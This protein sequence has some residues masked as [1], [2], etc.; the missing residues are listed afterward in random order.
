MNIRV[1]KLVSSITK[2]FLF[3]AVMVVPSIQAEP[4]MASD[5]PFTDAPRDMNMFQIEPTI[6]D[7]R[8]Y[9]SGRA[10][11]HQKTSPTLPYGAPIP[12]RD[13]APDLSKTSVETKATEKVETKTTTEKTTTDK[14]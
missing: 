7:E 11:R 10:E 12:D 9:T 6:I 14:K 3:A 13:A 5:K 1:S 8:Y 4:A 2:G